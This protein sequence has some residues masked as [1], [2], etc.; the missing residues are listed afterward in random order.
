M[1]SFIKNL[2]NTKDSD[3]IV[4]AREIAYVNKQLLNN[5]NVDTK[6]YSDYFDMLIVKVRS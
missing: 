5:K 3:L 4:R 6:Y 2:I 1:L